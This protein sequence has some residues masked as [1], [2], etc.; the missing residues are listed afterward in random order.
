MLPSGIY[1]TVMSFEVDIENRAKGCDLAIRLDDGREYD[2]MKRDWRALDDNEPS[3]LS[4]Q[5]MLK[6]PLKELA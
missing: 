1:A 5:D 2:G 3:G 4:I 6:T